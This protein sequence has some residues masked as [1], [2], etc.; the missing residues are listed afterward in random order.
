MHNKKQQARTSGIE[1]EKLVHDYLSA[2]GFTIL[3]KN[4]RIQAG[5]I[6]LI[7]RKQDLIVCVEVKTR[8]NQ[9]TDM[10]ELV[11]TWQQ[12]R[13]VRAAHHFLA[14]KRLDNVTCRFDVALV[15]MTP[16]P[17]LDYI[18]DAFQGE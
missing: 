18:Q 2:Q 3:A 5:E 16:E 6:D 13:I 8:T 17:R 12:Q 10:A 4:M 7:A 9:Q 11:T 15:A 1:G 14:K